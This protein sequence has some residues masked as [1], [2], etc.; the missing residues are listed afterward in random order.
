MPHNPTGT[1]WNSRRNQDNNC[2][3]ETMSH[4]PAR[5]SS[6][7][8]WQCAWSGTARLAELS[9]MHTDATT[10]FRVLNVKGCSCILPHLPSWLVPSLVLQ[11]TKSIA[12]LVSCEKMHQSSFLLHDFT[13]GKM[14]P[15]FMQLL[16]WIDRPNW[17]FAKLS[18]LSDWHFTW[19]G[20]KERRVITW[21]KTTHC[22]S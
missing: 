20:E 7:V 18:R 8:F 3:A 5:I 10:L 22:H 16:C 6:G 13:W 11:R 19:I 4:S 2:I 9:F 21:R 14:D 1:S 15:V 17:F 12:Q